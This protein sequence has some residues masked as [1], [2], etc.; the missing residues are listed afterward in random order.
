M[1]SALSIEFCLSMHIIFLDIDKIKPITKNITVPQYV[2]TTRTGV[3]K[4][5]V[6]PVVKAVVK[7]VVK[8]SIKTVVK[9]QLTI[10]IKKRTFYKKY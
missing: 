10:Y 4:P 1:S 3:V 5:V 7:S 8:Q 6:R 2:I 9:K